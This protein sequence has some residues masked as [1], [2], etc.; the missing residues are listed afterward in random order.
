M[1]QEIHNQQQ[2]YGP[3]TYTHGYGEQFRR[4]HS[5][6]RAIDEAAFFLPHLRAGMTL[7]DCGCGPGSITVDLAEIIA[8]GEAVGV[9]LAQAQ[10]NHAQDLAAQRGVSNVRFELAN[11]HDLPFSSASFDAVFAHNLL[12]HVRE[13]A[14]ALREM[15]RVL[16][17]SGVIGVQDDD[18]GTQLLEPM[19]PLLDKALEVFLRVATHNGGD[20]FYARHQKRL[21]R[22]AG[23][24][25]VEGHA[26]A[27]CYG[28]PSGSSCSQ[29]RQPRS[30]VNRRW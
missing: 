20:F 23:F 29:R 28:T 25:R 1:S 18:W 30:S 26:M 4:F 3:E 7:L 27:R 11:V 17:P 9:D 22:E 8:P 19:T 5:A 14:Q 21:L 6:R 15:R 16:K 2:I 24:L 13:P 12:E 10:I